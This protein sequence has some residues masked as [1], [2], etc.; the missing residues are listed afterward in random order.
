[1][2]ASISCRIRCCPA[3]KNNSASSCPRIVTDRRDLT[4]IRSDIRSTPVRD[5]VI[6]HKIETGALPLLDSRRR[7]SCAVGT[8]LSRAL[9]PPRTRK[10]R[11][12]NDLY[13]SFW[14]QTPPRDVEKE[15]PSSGLAWI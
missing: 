8:L 4:V 2:V 13:A 1:M 14:P 10:R 11:V 6:Q 3:L 7:A 5:L 15:R 9:R 12:I